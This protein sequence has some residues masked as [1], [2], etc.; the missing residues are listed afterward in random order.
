MGNDD[1]LIVKNCQAGRTEEFGLLYDRYIRKIYD[2]VYYKTMRR[3]TAEDLTSQT[4]LKALEKIDD[5]DGGKGAFG[6]WLYRIA[7]NTVIDHYRTRKEDANIEDI[8]DLAG[9]DDVARDIDMKAKLEKVEKYLAALKREHREIVMLHLWEG[10]T[11]KEIAEAL[12]K[13]EASCKMLYSRAITTL[14]REMPLAMFV[15]FALLKF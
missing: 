12:G 3:E 13:S 2:F 6:A 14:R 9:K 10:L 11:H 7:R 15:Y 1:V 4:F 5:F 8:W